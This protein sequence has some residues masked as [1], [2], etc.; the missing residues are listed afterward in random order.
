MFATLGEMNALIPLLLF[1]PALLLLAALLCIAFIASNM[2]ADKKGAPYVRSHDDKI[3]TMIEVGRIKPGEVVVDL[4]SGDGSL[5]IA[6]ARAGATCRG[7]EINPFLIWR[8]RRL[9]R[10]TECA[11][12][13]TITRENFFAASLGDADIVFVYLWPRTMQQLLE[14]CTRELKPGAR[15]VSNLFPI[16]QWTPYEERDMIFGY[17]P[18]HYARKSN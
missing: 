8:S 14:K 12:R 1:F 6:A 17:Y 5:L 16:P 3:K 10:K 13:I 2:I 11:N 7:I 18:P 9:I 15:V 4:G